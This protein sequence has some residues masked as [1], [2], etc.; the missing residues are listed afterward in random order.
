[1]QANNNGCES[2]ST[3]SQPVMGG[4]VALAAATI[5]SSLAN[6]IPVKITVQSDA[7]LITS[8]ENLDKSK[9]SEASNEAVRTECQVQEKKATADEA[10]AAATSISSSVV[11]AGSRGSGGSGGSVSKPG[12]EVLTLIA[13]WIKNAPNDFLDT[14]VIDEIK[15]FFNQLDSLKSSFRP[16][17]ARLKQ[18]LNLEVSKPNE[19]S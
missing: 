10:V 11:V 15:S 2:T 1:M 6:L 14:R 5:N 12:A 19:K 18:A 4:I 8:F 7:G 16:W 3:D 13:T 17:T 9:S